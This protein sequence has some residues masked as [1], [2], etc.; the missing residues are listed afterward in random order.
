MILLADQQLEKL[1]TMKKIARKLIAKHA[2]KSDEIPKGEKLNSDYWEWAHNP[3]HVSIF[4]R[5]VNVHIYDITAKG[6]EKETILQK[7]QEEK[8]KPNVIESGV[9]NKIFGWLV[10]FEQ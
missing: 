9:K 4:A 3:Y 2:Y 8:Q 7:Y 10:I 1:Q 5:G 6:Y